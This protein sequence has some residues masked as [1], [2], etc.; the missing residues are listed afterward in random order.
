[1]ELAQK[2]WLMEMVDKYSILEAEYWQHDR[3]S[4]Y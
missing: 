3:L 2:L 4:C 1:M